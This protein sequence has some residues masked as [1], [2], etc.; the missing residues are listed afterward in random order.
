VRVCG[1]AAQQRDRLVTVDVDVAVDGMDQLTR[2]VFAA[3]RC[4]S[5]RGTSREWLVASDLVSEC[6]GGC[7]LDGMCTL[8]ASS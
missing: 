4:S 5:V 2:Q 7:H 6:E 8:F 1:S 3:T